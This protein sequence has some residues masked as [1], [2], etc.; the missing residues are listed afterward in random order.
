MK[1]IYF[2]LA[3]FCLS[4][5]VATA[6]E[7]TGKQ[8]QQIVAGAEK[9][10]MTD[11]TAVPQFIKFREGEQPAFNTFEQWA[12][13]QL[14]LPQGNDF[15]LRHT[16]RDK[17][18]YIHYRYQ[19]TI[20]SI[21]VEGT[22]Y[23]VH[24]KNNM[25]ASANGM[26]FD[27]KM[28]TTGT[29]SLSE[30]VA[31]GKALDYTHAALYRWQS[32]SWEQHIKEVNNNPAATWYPK[33]ELVYAAKNGNMKAGEYRLCYKFDVYAQQPLS[34]K[35]VFVDAA[36]GEIINTTNRIVDAN[37]TA[38]VVTAYSG[39]HTMTTDSVSD[40]LYRLRETGRGLG[41]ETYNLEQGTN[42]VNTDFTDT[43]NNWNNVN[44]QL[45]Q[46]AGDA[47]W[48]SEITYDFFFNKYGRNSIDDAGLKLL[49]YVHY[50]VNYVNAFWDGTSMTYGDGDGNYT[51]LTSLDVTGHEISHGLTEYT[52]G[53]GGGEAGAMNEGFSDC[54]GIAIRQYGK[55]LVNIDW[56]IGDEIGGA[57]AFRDPSNPDNTN[58]PDTYLG[59]NWDQF[60]EVHQN[61]TIMSHSFYLAAEGGSGTNDNGDVYTVTGLGLNAAADIWYRMNTVYL[62]PSSDYADARYYAIQAAIDL[63]GPCTPEVIA[64]TNA[65]YAVGVGN[66]FV[67]GVTADF[68]APVV[69]FCQLPAEASF[70]NTSNNA[71]F[72]TWDFGDG[73]TSTQSSPTHTYTS[74]GTY[75]VKLI[76]DGGTC[77]IDSI[78]QTAYISVDSLN[79][80]LVILPPTGTS[81]TQTTC[82][83]QV[84][85]SGGPNADYTDNTNAIV[86]ISPIG[87]ATV[88][89]NFASF[90][91]EDT[92]DF[93]YVYDGP[94]IASPLIGA[95][96]GTTLPNG[97][98]INS[99]GGSITLQQTTDVGVVAPG[100]AVSWQCQ[101]ANVA[102]TPNFTANTTVTCNGTIHF[103]DL[104]TNG[105]V[106]WFWDFGDGN[107]STQQ[108]PTHTYTAS[109]TYDVQLSVTNSFGTNTLANNGYITVNIPAA[110]TASDVII[111]AGATADLTAAGA[112]SLM[113]FTQAAGGTAVGTGSPFTTPVISSNTT[114]YVESDVYP[115]QQSV[116]PVDNT[117]GAGTYFGLTN[118]HCLIFNC[119]SPV[120]LVSVK[121]FAQGTSDRTISLRD[122]GG[123]I[124]QQT[125]V[126]IADGT[127]IVP[128]NF[129]LPIG[130]NLQLGIEGNVFLFRN[131][132]GGTSYPYSIGG[133]VSIT[134]NDIGDPDYYYFFYDWKLQ[135]EPCI[136]ART[137]VNISV[138]TTGTASFTISAASNT[139]T[140]T[141]NS[142]GATSWFWDF[143]DSNTST[144]QNPVHTYTAN[145]TY[146]VTLTIN[147]GN[148]PATTS[149]N[150]DITTVGIA[151][152]QNATDLVV[153]PN[154]A[155]DV[156]TVSWK[157]IKSSSLS[158]Q[159]ADYTGR[160]V[161]AYTDQPMNA[162]KHTLQISSSQFAGGVYLLKVQAE[163]QTVV[164]KVTVIH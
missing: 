150:V 61:S 131:N 125:T 23:I 14:S 137:P 122:A 77:G 79:P 56:L 30:A 152:L 142:T 45:D 144:Q 149:Q 129:D 133:L 15:L 32:P 155:K 130:T 102:P 90:N 120:K 118:Y 27:R 157:Q 5:S 86:T 147:G 140:F 57:G 69:S 40:N 96:T 25:I 73:N 113:W 62:F 161:Y 112:D 93:L 41:I 81:T 2:L 151:E 42:V 47:H 101:L 111:C 68:T 85:D 20:N 33:G 8:A 72:Y 99:T 91:M 145:G 83:G 158:V 35:Y 63:Y 105:P 36:T 22:M 4:A 104:S 94:S 55:Q 132:A 18:G 54:M 39:T 31:L 116:G 16:T 146:T 160:L 37:S 26:L 65:W 117:F 71:G 24:T 97:G 52:S 21:P 7:L 60:G 164:R 88:T 95:Y 106:S 92:Y 48:G 82:T 38:T 128:L 87:A 17:N 67:F 43:D 127:S 66:E 76:A 19:Q 156:I 34:R 103:T 119:T 139:I 110:P 50:D 148:C 98:V 3:L 80:C 143:G 135:E 124:L 109:G 121:V 123:A 58:N 70:V 134:G 107:T 29:P 74:W 28:K 114:Y 53:L 141:D 44:A 162:G 1:N 9:V 84:F 10:R 46:Y 12:N 108:S 163:N 136:S 154:P 138:T 126:T 89:L 115:A 153:Y 64:T 49:S 159:V 59:N 6:A 75:T 100:F 13:R 11:V 78:T 51:P